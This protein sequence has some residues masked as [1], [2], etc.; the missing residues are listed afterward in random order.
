MGD[1]ATMLREAVKAFM[2]LRAT[3]DEL[4][5]EQAGR[6]W[7]GVSGARDLVRGNDPGE[8]RLGEGSGD[9]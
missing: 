1:K 3:F 4:T 5:E 2:D 6:V 9:V 8:R 7:L